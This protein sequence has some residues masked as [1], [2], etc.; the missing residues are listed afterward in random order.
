VHEKWHWVLLGSYYC[1]NQDNF[2]SAA[3]FLLEWRVEWILNDWQH[4]LEFKTIFLRGHFIRMCYIHLTN[5]WNS[6]FYV[7]KNQLY[8]VSLLFLILESISIFKFNAIN[9]G[10][11]HW[12]GNFKGG[13]WREVDPLS[14][15]E[16]G[17][18]GGN[19]H[20]L[21]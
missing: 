2:L 10:L 16:R 17:V 6:Q 15:R 3:Q 11:L 4:L 7:K 12:T 20:E 8:S 5:A 1:A 13:G 19:I 18:R 14:V 21:I 9:H